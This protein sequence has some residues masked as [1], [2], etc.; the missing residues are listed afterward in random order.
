LKLSRPGA[1]VIVDNVVRHGEV[2]D[3][4]SGDP[5]V[6]G[7]RRFNDAMVRQRTAASTVVQT[8]GVKGYDGFAISFVS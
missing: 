7:M 4:E 5:N 1:L 8:V 2:I 6:Q 3:S